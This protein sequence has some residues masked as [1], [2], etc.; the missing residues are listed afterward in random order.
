MKNI[1]LG[2]Y[3]MSSQKEQKQKEHSKDHDDTCDCGCRNLD[4]T[5]RDE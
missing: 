1:V 2:G 3:E 5:L 4:K